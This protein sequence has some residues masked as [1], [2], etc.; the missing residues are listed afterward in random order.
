MKKK[1]ES[2]KGDLFNDFEKSRIS[3]QLIFGGGTVEA[4]KSDEIGTVQGGCFDIEKDGKT[5]SI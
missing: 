5:T 3:G 2:L 1:L 4:A